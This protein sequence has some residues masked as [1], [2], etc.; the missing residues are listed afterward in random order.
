MSIGKTM[1]AELIGTFILVFLGCGAVHAAVLTGAQSGLWQVAVVWGIAI[2][3]ACYVTGG[4]SGAHIN[5]AMTVAFAV[6]RRFPWRRVPAYIISQ[7]TGAALAAATLYL[8]F[9]PHLAER[10]RAKGV[11]RGQA[12]SELTAMCYGEFFPN[13]GRLAAGDMP[14][15][16]DEHAALRKLVPH[17]TA[18]LAEV[19][20]TMLLA[21]AVF[22][23]TDSQNQ[24]GPASGQAP[25]FIG[26][27][28]AALISII[29]PLTQACFNPA[30]DFGPRLFSSIAG[31][32]TTAWPAD[33]VPVWLTVYIIAPTLGAVI[34]GGT[35]R[36]FLQNPHNLQ[37]KL[38]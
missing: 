24:G 26:L 20:G 12:G 31:W 30:R 5:P 2:M 36:Y 13:P 17:S 15:S 4:I 14:Y 11:I 22:G 19:I 34:G 32:G 35:Y 7:T 6:W 28:V 27:T 23:L 3:I 29:A 25:I 33:E 37:E 1:L 9:Q 8:L 10:E 16:P 38:G 21:I 18:F